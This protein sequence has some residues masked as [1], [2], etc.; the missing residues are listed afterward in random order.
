MIDPDELAEKAIQNI[1]EDRNKADYLV[2]QILSDI[3]A[4]KTNHQSAGMVL[5]KHLETMQRANEQLVKL[6]AL[7]KKTETNA[8]TG[9]SDTERDKLFEEIKKEQSEES[10][11]QCQD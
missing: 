1:V 7:F 8:F 11:E 10:S 9:F 6:T 2:T 3:Q 5:S 4:G